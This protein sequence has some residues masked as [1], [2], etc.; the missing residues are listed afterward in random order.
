MVPELRRRWEVLKRLLLAVA[1]VVSVGVLPAYA[2][3][4]WDCVYATT[5]SGTFEACVLYC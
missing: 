1:L 4:L 5:E 3:C 2:E